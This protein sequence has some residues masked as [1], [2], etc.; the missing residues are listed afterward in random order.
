MSNPI[1]VI[2]STR[3]EGKFEARHR[4]HPGVIGVGRSEGE[5]GY[6]LGRIIGEVDYKR[7]ER[8]A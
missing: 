7:G 6:R 2:P 5:A 8:S 3:Y 1:E 4:D